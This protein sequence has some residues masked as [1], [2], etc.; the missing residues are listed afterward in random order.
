MKKNYDLL[1]Y[2]LV[3]IISLFVVTNNVNAEEAIAKIGDTKYTTL[4]E[5][6]D[7]ADNNETPT[8]I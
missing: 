4:Q 6:I 7:A 3:M 2:I 1:K 8:L 5:A